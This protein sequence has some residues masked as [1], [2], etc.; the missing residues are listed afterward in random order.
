MR[1][2]TEVWSSVFCPDQFFFQS[3]YIT[4]SLTRPGRKQFVTTRVMRDNPAR[5]FLK[6]HYQE[7]Y[8]LPV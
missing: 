7:L 3:V 5:K 8:F 1:P 6:K 2:I 4:R